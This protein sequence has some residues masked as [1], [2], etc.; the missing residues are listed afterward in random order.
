VRDFRG[1][2]IVVAVV[3]VLATMVWLVSRPGDGPSRLILEDD[4]PVRFHFDDVPITSFDLEVSEPRVHGSIRSSFSSW[5]VILNCAEPEGC[6]GE[7]ALE[8]TFQSG[9]ERREITIIALCDAPSG[10]EL[11]FEGL[12]DPP[13]PVDRVDGLTLEVIERGVPGRRDNTVQL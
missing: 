1:P 9:R 13:L 2:L 5:L 7:F 12:Q 11:R 8:V 3:V 4:T 10:G 6:A